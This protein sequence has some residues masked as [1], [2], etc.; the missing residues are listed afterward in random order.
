MA[1]G[2]VVTPAH[3]SAKTDSAR[4]KDGDSA[5]LM[6]QGVRAFGP[7]VETACCSQCRGIIVPFCSPADKWARGPARGNQL[8]RKNKAEEVVSRPGLEPGTR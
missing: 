1:H 3:L 5:G 4:G 7:R 8:K 6:S 2:R